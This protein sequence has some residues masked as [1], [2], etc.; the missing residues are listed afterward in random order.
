M[1]KIKSF[2]LMD[3]SIREGGYVP[4][5]KISLDE[6]STLVDFLDSCHLTHLEIATVGGSPIDGKSQI[7]LLEAA[8]SSSRKVKIGA[9]YAPTHVSIDYDE[10]GQYLEL[11]DFIRI[12]TNVH[13]IKLA[14]PWIEKA[15]K[16]NIPIFFQMIRSPAFSPLKVAQTAKKIEKM[17]VDVV[18]LVDSMGSFLPSDV[19]DYVKCIK[20][21]ISIPL[22]F[23]GHDNLGMALSNSIT[24]LQEGCEWVDAS[25]FGCGRQAGNCQLETLL[26]VLLKM[27]AKLN[28]DLKLLLK[29]SEQIAAPIFNMAR[30]VKVFDSWSAFQN[31]DLYP[32][33]TFEALSHY[34]GLDILDFV[35]EMKKIKGFVSFNEEELIKICKHFKMP[36]DK[37]LK[38][39]QK[40]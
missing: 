5:F 15:K 10:Y 20:N 19:V 27:G 3:V 1:K 16:K 33:Q 12:G 38:L 4:H 35:E 28:F 2:H 18:Y 40:S 39:F 25:I 31:L 26:L 24:A 14:K 22:G 37:I 8:K 13:E 7:A 36:Y 21:E 32:P 11:L 30:G 17:G 6:V 29:T 23:H 34:S 9:L